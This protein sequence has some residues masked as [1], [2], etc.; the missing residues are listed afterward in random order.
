M[1][2][3]RY[4]SYFLAVAL[5]TWGITKLELASP[6]SLRLHV[7]VSDADALGTSEFSP[8]EIIQAIMLLLCGGVMAWVAR[9]CPSQAPLAIPLGGL[10]LAFLIRESDYFLDRYL[11]DN[12]WQSLIAVVAAVVI[13]YTYRNSRRV[14]IALARIWPSPGLTLLFS[15]AVI[16]FVFVRLVGHEPLWQSI[17]GENYLRVTKLA[18]EEFIE[19]SGYF[20]WMIGTVE[21]AFQARAIAYR[22]PQPAA[23]R[24]REKR[25]HDSERPF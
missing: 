11:V 21:Y 14:R 7:V 2:W 6:G 17:I 1:A 5:V 23:R 4:L 10:A 8:V 16:L 25:R 20:L 24:R 9:Y 18:I 22:E 19:L 3:I 12:L 13:V 15:G